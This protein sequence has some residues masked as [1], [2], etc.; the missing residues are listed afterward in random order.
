MP[1]FKNSGKRGGYVRKPLGGYRAGRG[2]RKVGGV[3]RSR[4]MKN[5]A[6]NKFFGSGINGK[7]FGKR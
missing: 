5:M 4:S 1:S 7:R 2:I 6:K 3:S